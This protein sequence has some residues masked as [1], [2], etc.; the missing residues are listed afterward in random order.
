MG[1]CYQGYIS[2]HKELWQALVAALPMILGTVIT[3]LVIAY[4]VGYVRYEPKVPSF[5][6]IWA[7]N[8][9]F[10]VVL[11]E[12]AFFRGFIL[13]GLERALSSP[14]MA[15]LLSSLAFGL[16]HFAGG[17]AYVGFSI[18]AGIGYGLAY[19]RSGRIEM[20]M[21]TH[22]AVNATHFFLLTYPR[23]S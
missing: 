6:L 3:L 17:L 20:A 15:L 4:A 2:N 21:I 5:S 13:R 22:F 8:N 11:C 12:E 18:L 14:R 19:Q 9:L 1:C 10:F 16:A 7:I 23:T